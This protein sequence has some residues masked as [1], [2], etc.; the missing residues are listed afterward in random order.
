MHPPCLPTDAEEKALQGRLRWLEQSGALAGCEAM[1]RRTST[2]QPHRFFLDAIMAYDLSVMALHML[3]CDPVHSPAADELHQAMLTTVCKCLWLTAVP[4][5]ANASKG[6]VT[7]Q[8][9]AA[10]ASGA[11]ASVLADLTTRLGQVASESAHTAAAAAGQAMD[12]AKAAAEICVN[13]LT[14]LVEVL[15]RLRDIHPL[16]E[17]SLQYQQ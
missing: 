6:P 10:T 9:A 5:S 8:A 1:L 12:E 4:H 11:P 7:A 14:M 3:W 13:G 2:L 17:P 16:A 15:R